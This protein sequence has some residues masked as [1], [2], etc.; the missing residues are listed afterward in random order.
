MGMPEVSGIPIIS[1][2]EEV[3]FGKC[4]K[5]KE[6]EGD[7]GMKGK[8]RFTDGKTEVRDYECPEGFVPGTLKGYLKK[9]QD[10]NINNNKE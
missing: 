4:S 2:R 7:Q 6:Q 9:H 1:K 5:D 3:V 8:K 10:S